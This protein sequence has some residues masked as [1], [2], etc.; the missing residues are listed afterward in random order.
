[1]RAYHETY[2]EVI[3]KITSNGIESFE[4]CDT[5]DRETID[6]TYVMPADETRTPR[7]YSQLLVNTTLHEMAPKQFPRRVKGVWM[8]NQHSL[9]ESRL[10]RN[11]VVEVDFSSVVNDHTVVAVPWD[12]AK[13]TYWDTM[14]TFEVA[15]EMPVE[16]LRKKC[17]QYWNSATIVESPAD[18]PDTVC[19]MYANTPVLD[20]SY[21]ETTSHISN[22][23]MW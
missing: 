13:D 9:D 18:I 10:G 3:D 19:E 7:A 4:S 21:I 1:M 6:N 23:S 11:A 5:V 22:T 14:D 12:V 2:N 16:T 8:F 20:P 17:E 15:E